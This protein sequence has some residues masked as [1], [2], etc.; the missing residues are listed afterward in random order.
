M[1]RNLCTIYYGPERSWF[2]SAPV[3][4][5]CLQFAGLVGTGR[6][7]SFFVLYE[8]RRRPQKS[9]FLVGPLIRDN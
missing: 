8:P 4:Y 5:V 9:R 7:S 6:N 2:A 3:M 1:K